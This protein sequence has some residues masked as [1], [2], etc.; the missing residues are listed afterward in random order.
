MRHRMWPWP[1]PEAGR[2]F[3]GP[4][5]LI[6]PA[7][8]GACGL[9]WAS[10]GFSQESPPTG[11]PSA[12]PAETPPA[13]EEPEVIIPK[14]YPEERYLEIWQRSPFMLEAAPEPAQAQK[15]FARDY[16]LGGYVESKSETV[17]YLKNQKTGETIRIP[18]FSKPA[19][20]SPEFK[21]IELK[22]DPKPNLV[23]ATISLNGEIAEIGR[24]PASFS[25][26]SSPGNAPPTGDVPGQPAIDPA[27]GGRPLAG[28][29]QGGLTAA[30]RQPIGT[31]NG[32][33]MPALP[34]P[35]AGGPDAASGNA[36]YL[37]PAAERLRQQQQAAAAAAQ[38]AGVPAP[39]AGSTGPNPPG[40][41][42]IVLPT[43]TPPPVP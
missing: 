30:P 19:D 12:P 39:N 14:A 1:R 43:P 22:K 21:L 41:R 17:V 29:P 25:Q 3:S 26:P 13:P 4:W 23:K 37:N 27:A 35:E 24:D 34:G 32:V 40:R 42:R 2:L 16:F 8:A 10:P 28:P 20:G 36:P 7:L 33:K 9:Y 15:S 5:R 31:P 6:V 18:P 38:K 11:D